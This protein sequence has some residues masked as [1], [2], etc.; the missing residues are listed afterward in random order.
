MGDLVNTRWVKHWVGD[1]RRCGAERLADCGN[2]IRG[3]T[4]K[5]GANGSLFD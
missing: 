5:K 2:D 1:C 4:M 3:V